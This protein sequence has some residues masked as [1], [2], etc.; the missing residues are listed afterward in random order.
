MR[1]HREVAKREHEPSIKFDLGLGEVART[2]LESPA[3]IMKARA[4]ATEAN[5]RKLSLQQAV[6]ETKTLREISSYMQKLQF[7]EYGLRYRLQEFA[8]SPTGRTA[9]KLDEALAHTTRLATAEYFKLEGNMD[10]RENSPAHSPWLSWS[11]GEHRR[12]DERRHRMKAVPQ[13]RRAMPGRR[14]LG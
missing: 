6:Q 10:G 13:M 9:K 7:D 1:E 5:Y 2:L 12:R 8:R 4:D 14:F 3:I 11:V